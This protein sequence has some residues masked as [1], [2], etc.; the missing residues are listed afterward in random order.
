MAG[1]AERAEK[2]SREEVLAD[3]MKAVV[4]VRAGLFTGSGFFITPSIVV[5]NYHVTGGTRLVEIGGR[6][7]PRSAR[8]LK[9]APNHDLVLLELYEPDPGQSVLELGSVE[10]VV[11]G[12]EVVTIGSAFGLRETVTRGIVS[13]IRTAKGVTFLQTDAA[14]NPGNS[15]GPLLGL[16]GKVVGINTAKL[17]EAESL[18]LAIAADHAAAL[19]EG[20]SLEPLSVAAATEDET[21]AM[22][23]ETPR[24]EPQIPAASDGRASVAR[25]AARNLQEA[26]KPLSAQADQIDREYEAIKWQCLVNID[27]YYKAARPT[28]ALLLSDFDASS[29]PTA[30]CARRVGALQQLASYVGNQ[31]LTLSAVAERQGVR[32]NAIRSIRRI[33]RLDW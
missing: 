18:G 17:Q 29:T 24:P 12:Q 7:E 3:A 6:N 9:S 30:D 8:L 27:V 22:F 11:I 4:S 14:I 5:T 28:V 15:G 2:Q 33:Y 19:F 26:L 32:P 31:V 13:A 16:D 1:N 25:S 10:D 23:L 21:L 20:R